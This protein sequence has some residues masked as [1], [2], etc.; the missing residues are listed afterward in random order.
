M[1]TLATVKLA[2]SAQD[3]RVHSANSKNN[4]AALY[5]DDVFLNDSGS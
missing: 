3:E 2:L 5:M 1:S 4:A